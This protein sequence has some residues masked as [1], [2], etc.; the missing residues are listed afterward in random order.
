VH[1]AIDPAAVRFEYLPSPGPG[2]QNVNKVASAVR[3][4]L[5]VA[6]AAL[7]EPVRHRLLRLAGRRATLGGEVVIHA[8]RFR[9]QARNRE[10]AV[11]RLTALVET[12]LEPPRARK[13]TKPTR[14][15]K[16]RRLSA[17]TRRATVKANRRLP[18]E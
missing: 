11:H 15:S 12:A 10:D 14:A 17:K 9:D 13:P 18:P 6:R 16:E 8:T 1:P 2:G 7:P 3:L 5:D 4:R